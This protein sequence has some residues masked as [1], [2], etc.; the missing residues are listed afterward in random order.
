MFND[1]TNYYYSWQEFAK[2][3]Y[4]NIFFSFSVKIYIIV[5]LLINVLLWLFARYIYY[6]IDGEQM[7]L[8]YNVDFGIDYYG[9]VDEIYRLPV[10]GLSI[11]FFNFLIFIFLSN[12]NKDKKFF[13]HILFSTSIIINLI[14]L[15]AISLIYLVNFK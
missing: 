3:Y 1:L 4:S 11:I 10:I 2:K 8:H 6:G 12:K 9:S 7:A 14:L 13:A 5:S 15:L